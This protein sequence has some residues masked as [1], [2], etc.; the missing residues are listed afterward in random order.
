MVILKT[1]NFDNKKMIDLTGYSYKEVIN[2][3]KLMGINYSIEGSGYVYEQ[4][5]S[6]DDVINDDDTLVIKLKDKW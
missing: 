4:S 2:I 6:V 3:L 1:N 5:I